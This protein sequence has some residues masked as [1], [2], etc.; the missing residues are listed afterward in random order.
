MPNI[1]ELSESLEKWYWT[2]GIQRTGVNALSRGGWYDRVHRAIVEHKVIQIAKNEYAKPTMAVWG[3]SQSG[4]STL[5][6]EF[7]DFGA[8]EDG[9]GSA[10]SWDP[11]SPARFSGDNQGGRVAVLNPYSHGA[12]ASGCVT[13]FQLA[14]SVRFDKYPV[15]IKFA[16]EMEVLLSLAVGYLSETKATNDKRE[17]V[18]LTASGV[19]DILKQ[20][21]K[22]TSSAAQQPD[23]E[24]YSLLTELTDVVE[25]LIDMELP[26]YINL[27]NEWESIRRNI[28]NSDVLASGEDKVLNLAAAL[29]W[30]NW[31][32]MT[33]LYKRL[34]GKRRE[35]AARFGGK[36]VYCSIEMAALMLNIA[37]ASYYNESAYVKSLV[38]ACSTSVIRDD[39]GEAIAIT[40]DGDRPFFRDKVDFALGQGLVSLIIVKLK[41]SVMK[42]GNPTVYKLLQKADLLDFP[43]VANEH[44]SADPLDNEKLALDYEKDGKYPLLGLTQVMKRGK[45]ASIVVSSARNLN[46]DVFSL[47][48]RMPAGTLYP[49]QPG[50]L[51]NGIRSWFKSMGK[52]YNP[53]ARDRQLQMNLILTFS[54]SL[55]NEVKASGTGLAGLIDVFGRL[56]S[57]GDLANPEVVNTFCVNYPQFPAGKFAPEI[58]GETELRSIIDRIAAD[59]AF[60]SQF[61]NSAETL[62]CMADLEPGQHGGRIYLF[63]QMLTQ[64]DASKRPELLAAKEQK[65]QDVWN[66]CMA[67]ALPPEGNVDAKREGD[68]NKILAALA[69]SNLDVDAA[70]KEILSFQNIEP[71]SLDQIPS[72]HHMS[73]DVYV[74]KQIDK[75]IESAKN[76][77]LQKEM[78]FENAEHR[79]RLLSYLRSRINHWQ[80]RMWL[81]SISSILANSA[82]RRECRRLLATYLNNMI[83]P[84]ISGHKTEA[85]CVSCLENIV[86]D[87]N[88]S[89]E[90]HPYYI[91]VV[92][93]FVRSMEQLRDT[94][95][96]G[97][98][99][100]VQP[101]DAEL[102]AILNT[103]EI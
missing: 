32:G 72:G 40:K 28:L 5:L 77:P 71:E 80:I 60:R 76:L 43:G 68:I 27:K 67:E 103:T 18:Q 20:V 85:E 9:S 58:Q 87:E 12:D 34:H 102:T 37:S 64:L 55:V 75:W 61:G 35:L 24:V 91:A 23:A 52:R 88:R 46:I 63:E 4:K 90:N 7:I 6:A 47:L 84:A 49:S 41:D 13:R 57:M 95:M 82:E 51:L 79:S 66:L 1:E 59:R 99:R 70:A 25:V 45:T 26:R 56:K 3:P 31:S 62:R 22:G 83:Y 14:E 39:A 93:P 30:D 36:P 86:N 42:Q 21:S 96:E 2:F 38:D 73:F 44:K 11:E 19:A 48:V 15:E 69:A 92:A 78:G 53:L 98:T 17:V 8:A 65:L 97:D 16:S 101:G 94:P 54:A 81:E 100:G 89:K 33:D 50:Q 74:N 10:L 29:L